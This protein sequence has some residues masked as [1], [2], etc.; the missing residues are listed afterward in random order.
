MTKALRVLALSL[1]A[2][3]TPAAAQ[4]APGQAPDK[5]VEYGATVIC[6]TQAQMERFVALFD[7]DANRAMDQVNTE[8]SNPTACIGATMAFMRG[9]ELSKASNAQGT[10]KI[11]QVLVFG[12]DTPQGFQAVQPVAFFSIEKTEEI[13]I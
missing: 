2:A 9:G 10:Y 3:A 1:F 4:Q 8:E 6:D 13:S 11:I 7:G 5:Q 12:I